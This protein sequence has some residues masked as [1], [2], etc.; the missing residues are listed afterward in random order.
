MKPH[1][2][3]ARWMSSV[4]GTFSPQM[5]HQPHPAVPSGLCALDWSGRQWQA[6]PFPPGSLRLQP[7][8]LP[9]HSDPRLWDPGTSGIVLFLF[10]L[11]ALLIFLF[12]LVKEKFM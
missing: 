11:S 5:S 1:S 3:E 4:G 6:E 2:P 9:D 10:L 12:L 8:G 7:R